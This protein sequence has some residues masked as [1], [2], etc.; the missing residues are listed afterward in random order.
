MPASRSWPPTNAATCAPRACAYWNCFPSL[1]TFGYSSAATPEARAQHNRP[2]TYFG[3]DFARPMLDVCAFWPRGTL[4][5]DY[6]QPVKSDVPVLLLSGALDPITPQAH[7]EAAKATLSHGTHLVVPGV[8]HGTS[9]HG[10][11]P[12]LIAQFLEAGSGAGLDG[13][14]VDG[15]GR[16]PFFVSFAGPTP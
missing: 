16:P 1:S 4:P 14:C 5:A 9:A 11:V 13:G 10:C 6:H 8:G 2:D 15:L 7:A 12:E 3:D